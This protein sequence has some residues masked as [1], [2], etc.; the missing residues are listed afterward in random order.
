MKYYPTGYQPTFSCSPG[1]VQ[2]ILYIFDNAHNFFIIYIVLQLWLSTILVITINVKQKCQQID[3][4]SPSADCSVVLWKILKLSAPVWVVPMWL[5]CCAEWLYYYLKRTSRNSTF[6]TKDLR[7]ELVATWTCQEL[8]SSH[9]N[10][11][12]IL[13][14]LPARNFAR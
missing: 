10:S 1:Y 9:M 11:A 12:G 6:R 7:Q 2:G 4:V 14:F 5:T 8:Y 3:F 13:G